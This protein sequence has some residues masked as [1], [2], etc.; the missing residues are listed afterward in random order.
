[1]VTDK[2]EKLY[3]INKKKSL[4]N[5]NRNSILYKYNE[6]GDDESEICI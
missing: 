2:I 6:L 4:T 3:K 1:M 5:T